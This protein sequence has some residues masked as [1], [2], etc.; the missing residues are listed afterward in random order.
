MP[1]FFLEGAFGLLIE[2]WL[3][4]ASDKDA[5][6]RGDELFGDAGNRDAL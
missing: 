6:G 1:L 4:V 5:L 2:H 3:C